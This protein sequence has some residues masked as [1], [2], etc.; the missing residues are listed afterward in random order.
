MTIRLGSNTGIYRTK[1]RIE[2]F[3][4]VLEHSLIELA[5]WNVFEADAICDA[6]VSTL[7]ISYVLPY[8]TISHSSVFQYD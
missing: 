2:T 5:R 4:S 8:K 3:C 1:R 7:E 6:L